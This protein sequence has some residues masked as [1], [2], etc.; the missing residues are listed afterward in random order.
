MQLEAESGEA[1]G[2]SELGSVRYGT[3]L[4]VGG[5]GGA[6]GQG[7]GCRSIQKIR[8]RHESRFKVKQVDVRDVCG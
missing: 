6:G 1:E 8:G 3:S 5:W 7:G 4:R 2:E